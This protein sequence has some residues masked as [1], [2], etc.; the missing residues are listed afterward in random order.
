MVLNCEIKEAI[1][2]TYE[3][4]VSR[5]DGQA[6]GFRGDKGCYQ[7]HQ[8]QVEEHLRVRGMNQTW[9]LIRRSEI[10]M[11]CKLSNYADRFHLCGREL[12]LKFNH[13]IV[14]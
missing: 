7:V 1:A 6:R 5:R 4:F 12:K 3:E 14:G 10:N 11:P 9:K 2:E 8:L 13:N